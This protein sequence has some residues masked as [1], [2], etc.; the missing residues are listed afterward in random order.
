MKIYLKWCG[1]TVIN[2]G[3]LHGHDQSKR[4]QKLLFYKALLGWKFQMFSYIP[5]TNS[6]F[7]GTANLFCRAKWH[8]YVPLRF[9]HIQLHLV[10]PSFGSIIAMKWGTSRATQICGEFYDRRR[11][12]WVKKGIVR[13][14]YSRWQLAIFSPPVMVSHLALDAFKILCYWNY[15]IANSERHIPMTSLELASRTAE[16]KRDPP[17]YR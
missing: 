14:D 4:G 7:R 6:I 16:G 17:L 15:S 2:C 10:L 12:Y 1:I 11:T 9:Y 3:E 5:E 8:I 13:N